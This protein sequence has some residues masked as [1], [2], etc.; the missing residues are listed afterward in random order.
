MSI[1][2]SAAEYHCKCCGELVLR[3][4]ICERCIIDKLYEAWASGK[5]PSRSILTLAY[6]RGIKPIEIREEAREDA[7]GRIR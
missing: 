3:H 2:Y 7:K 1:K 4:K 5:E 6:K